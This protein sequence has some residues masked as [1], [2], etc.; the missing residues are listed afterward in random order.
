MKR[1]RI[2]VGHVE[3]TPPGRG[4]TGGWGIGFG[5]LRVEPPTEPAE[6]L[7][8]TAI[9]LDDGDGRRVVLV[10]ADLHC[11]SRPIWEAVARNAGLQPD[12]LVLCGSHTHNGPGQ[13]YGGRLFALGSTLPFG[14]SRHRKWLVEQIGRAVTDAIG[15][16]SPGGV[17]VVRGVV[18]GVGNNRAT[19][20]WAHYGQPV[21]DDF[22]TN[23]PGALLADEPRRAA[24]YRD[25]RLTLLV[26]RSD[27]GR[28]RG[29]LA[30]Y[31]VHPNSL[32][33]KHP[34][35]SADLYGWARHH[36]EAHDGTPVGFGGGVAGDVSPLTLADDGHLL[37]PNEAA[38]DAQGPDLASQLGRRIGEAAVEL[39][40]N[41][42]PEAFTLAVAHEDW[43]AAAVG[44]RPIY[45]MTQLGAGVDGPSGLWSELE[46]GIHS[47]QGRR[48]AKHRFPD[49]DPQHPKVPWLNALRVPIT[50]RWLFD[51]GIPDSYPL[52]VIGVGDHVLATVP[53]EPT[54]MTGWRIEQAMVAATGASTASVI[55]YAGDYCAY[56]VTPEEYLEQRYEAA[57]TVF[58]R[59]ASTELQ[60]ALNRLAGSLVTGPADGEPS[61]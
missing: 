27:D 59:D 48:M 13:P 17:A 47:P 10:N 11:G 3:I 30:W 12:Q 61:D 55:G 40:G 19:P 21:I 2:G 5:A 32:G 28:H 16:L 29:A 58:G 33:P 1:C 4:P 51:L 41:A 7:F 15:S 46:A 24:R 22:L 52:H 38:A 35:F 31:G 26:V 54:V 9:A 18:D 49:G 23:G 34:T 36:V 37:P 8:A 60:A 42:T 14:L 43:S 20:A 6:R 56:W 44:S 57:S 50:M 45:G 53:G 25:P 39:L